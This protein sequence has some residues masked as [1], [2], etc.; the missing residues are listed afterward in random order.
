MNKEQIELMIETLE[1]LADEL[2]DNSHGSLY[3]DQWALLKNLKA[4]LKNGVLADVSNRKFSKE[5]MKHSYLEG[6]LKRAI[7]SG[8]KHDSISQEN[9]VREFNNWMENYYDC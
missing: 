7:M 8:L 3:L 2:S 5:S 4:K 1:E 6:Y 9:A